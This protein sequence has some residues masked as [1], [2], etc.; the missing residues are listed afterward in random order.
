MVWRRDA[1]ARVGVVRA[2]LIG[3]SARESGGPVRVGEAEALIK[4][5]VDPQLGTLPQAKASKERDIT[6]FAALPAA[7]QAIGTLE[8]RADS[9]ISLLDECSL[10]VKINVVRVHQGR[11]SGILTR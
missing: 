4:F 6:G 11:R 2:K 10:A 8:G 9:R 5:R 7:G 3:L 1:R